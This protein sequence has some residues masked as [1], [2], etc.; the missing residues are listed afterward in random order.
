M[1]TKKKFEASLTPADK[2]LY[3]VNFLLASFTPIDDL[4][5]DEEILLNKLQSR[6]YQNRD[7]SIVRFSKNISTPL[8]RF[9]PLPSEDE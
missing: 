7:F 3:S 9:P 8:S 2:R 6:H 4:E 1:I 5:R